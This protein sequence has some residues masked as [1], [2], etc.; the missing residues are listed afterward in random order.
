MLA[1][2]T[3]PPKISLTRKIV[4]ATMSLILFVG[5]CEFT[6]KAIG[7]D[8]SKLGRDLEATPIFYRIPTEPFGRAHYKRPG[9][10]QWTGRV[11][12]AQMQKIG[13]DGKWLP[14]EEVITLSY[15][16]DGFR[17]PADLKS[18]RVVMLGDSFTELGN[19]SDEEL[20]STKLGKLLGQT[21]KNLG[22]SHTGLV[23]Q[24]EYLREFGISRQTM[25]AFGELALTDVL[26]EYP[27]LKA[28]SEDI[29]EFISRNIISFLV[30]PDQNPRTEIELERYVRQ[31]IIPGLGLQ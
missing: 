21:V 15:D 22:V 24:T 27:M 28:Q 1:T 9:G 5:V 7:F 18:W 26:K 17:N 20:V 31:R 13:Y 8:F 2:P 23:N 30:M 3:R 14:Q 19:L 11:I 6:F 25:Q 16:A 29:C 12:S 4:F 10:Q